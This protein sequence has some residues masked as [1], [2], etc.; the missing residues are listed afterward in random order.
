[1]KV[2]QLITPE[3]DRIHGYYVHGHVLAELFHQAVSAHYPD[4]DVSLQT[5]ISKGV[6]ENWRIAYYDANDVPY[7]VDCPRDSFGAFPVTVVYW[8]KALTRKAQNP[9]IQMRDRSRF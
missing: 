2:H 1:M 3:T 4:A 6:W 7:Y 9:I 8:E 5:V